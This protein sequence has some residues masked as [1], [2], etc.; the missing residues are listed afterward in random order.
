MTDRK[1][2]WKQYGSSMEAVWQ[3]YE[4]SM[5]EAGRYCGNHPA[6]AQDSVMAVI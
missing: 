3:M 2:V 6:A 5:K 1:T 4:S